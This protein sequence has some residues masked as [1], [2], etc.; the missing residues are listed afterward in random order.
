MS[1]IARCNL[2]EFRVQIKYFWKFCYE[3]P[4]FWGK[5]TKI[6]DTNRRS[7]QFKCTSASKIWKSCSFCGFFILLLIFLQKSNINKF[8]HFSGI[9]SHFI[10]L[11]HYSNPLPSKKNNNLSPT[12]STSLMYYVLFSAKFC[13][14][15]LTLISLPVKDKY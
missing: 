8:F 10:L 5:V 13:Y 15:H 9:C 12:R 3:T 2:L 11:H 7:S 6:R 1:D 14:L 4:Q